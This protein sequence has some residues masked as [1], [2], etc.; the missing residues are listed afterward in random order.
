[1]T[2]TRL[3]SWAYFARVLEDICG[4]RIFAGDFIFRGQAKYLWDLESSFDRLRRDSLVSRERGAEDVLRQFQKALEYRNI[5][6]LESPELPGLAQHYG[7]PT[8][9]LDWSLS[10][11]V[12]AFF[13]CAGA[14]RADHPAASLYVL[15]RRSL[16][17]NI[18]SSEIE[19]I[20]YYPG[21]NE[22]LRNQKGCFTLL[23]SD[24]LSIDSLLIS[25]GMSD[26]L[27]KIKIGKSVYRDAIRHLSS[28]DVTYERLFSGISGLAEDVWLQVLLEEL[29]QS[30]F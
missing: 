8:R 19:I 11:Y 4:D 15:D 30:N 2:E 22:R 20:E 21:Q 26:S 18:S 14:L 13:A 1:M 29:S 24:F 28:M 7:L 17:E 5:G 9:F 3:K 25:K 27:T 12:A 23:K 16:E 6:R 10:P